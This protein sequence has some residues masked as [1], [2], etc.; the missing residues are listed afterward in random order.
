MKVK[1]RKLHKSAQVP[2]YKT[3]GSAGC[4]LFAS[5][6]AF[7]EPG[8]SRGVHTDIAVE[9]PEGYEG[10][11]RS[12]SGMGLFDK[13]VVSL[14]VGTIDSDYRGEVIVPLRNDGTVGYRI[15]KGQRIAQMVFA[16]VDRGEFEEVDELGHTERGGGGCG[17]TG[18]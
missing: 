18:K 10:Q 6:E 16:L 8:S 14:G 5:E 7:I 1:F 17:S 13:I 3:S 4:D 12:R 2:E 9:I 11:I 15:T